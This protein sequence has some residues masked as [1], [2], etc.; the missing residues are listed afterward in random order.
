MLIAGLLID[1]VYELSQ[2]HVIMQSPVLSIMTLILFFASY[3]AFPFLGLGL[4]KSLRSDH[5]VSNSKL[6]SVRI[7]FFVQL[8]FQIFIAYNA[9]ETIK[10]IMFLFKTGF[11]FYSYYEKDTLL[12]VAGIILGLLTV[13]LEIFTFPLIG[14]VKK[15][16]ASIMEQINTIGNHEI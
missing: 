3:F 8:I 5:D 13:Y 4:L 2:P 15:N 9:I 16:Y 7:V 1:I 14:A 12:E 11:K 10:K 6:I